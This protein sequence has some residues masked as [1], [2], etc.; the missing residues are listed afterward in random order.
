MGV[1]VGIVVGGTIVSV[2]DPLQALKAT[3]MKMVSRKYLTRT[4]YAP[5]NKNDRIILPDFAKANKWK[6]QQASSLNAKRRTSS[7][8]SLGWSTINLQKC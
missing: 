3:T 2:A 1:S 5:K 8:V 6:N 4:V 7:R